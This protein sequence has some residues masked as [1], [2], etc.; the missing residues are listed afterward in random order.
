MRKHL[1]II[2]RQHSHNYLINESL[3]QGTL[4]RPVWHNT[5]I[6]IEDPAFFGRNLEIYRVNLY[7]EQYNCVALHGMGGMGKTALAQAVGRWQHERERWR[8][9]VWLLEWRNVATVG[10]SKMRLGSLFEP[11]MDIFSNEFLKS[12]FSD[13]QL[14]LILD[15]L[16]ELIRNEK[17]RGELIRLIKDLLSCRGVKLLLTSRDDIPTEIDHQRYELQEMRKDDAIRAFY[18][19]AP[20]DKDW[21]RGEGNDT[22]FEAIMAF[23]DGYPFPIR[24]AGSYLKED[25]FSNLGDLYQRLGASLTPLRPRNRQETRENSLRVSLEISYQALPVDVRDT[26]TFL[27]LFPDGLTEVLMRYVLDDFSQEALI[28]LL[29]YSMAEYI[30]VFPTSQGGLGGI[31][32]SQGGLEGIKKQ[33]QSE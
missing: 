17:E 27:A 26:F 33:L 12:Y 1:N 16:D 9:G 11:E 32:P 8:D 31:K 10:Q 2:S 18:H 19:Y 24:L 30:D 28:T 23:L 7:L 15:D 22:V 20:A 14:L 29:Q 25:R 4:I 5:N 6:G 3:Q 21:Q 13:K